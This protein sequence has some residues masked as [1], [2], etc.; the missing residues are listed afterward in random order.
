MK[1]IKL[2]LIIVGYIISLLCIKNY[3]F[4]ILGVIFFIYLFIKK[5]PYKYYLYGILILFIR[6]IIIY[7]NYEYKNVDNYLVILNKENYVILINNKLQQFVS[8]DLLEL[9]MFSVLQIEGNYKQLIQNSNFDLFS[10]KDY[11]SYRN[12]EY[13]LEVIGYRVLSDVDTFKPKLIEFLLNGLDKQSSSVINMLIFGNK[14]DKE[15]YNKLINL[16]VV[17]L[18]VVSGF[19]FNALEQVLVR[20]KVKWINI[21]I[22]ILFAFYLYILDFQIAA[23]RAFL[24]ICMKLLSKYLKILNNFMSYLLVLSLFLIINPFYI[25]HQ[26]FI[27]S[28]FLTF[29]LIF[30]KEIKIK[31][32]YK[33][34]IV[35]L[36]ALPII[37]S[38]NNEI[39]VFSFL[40]QLVLTP[41]ITLLFFSSLITLIF[42]FLSPLYLVLVNIFILIVN[43]FDFIPSM[44]IIKSFNF[45]ELLLYFLLIL[46]IIYLLA[47]KYNKKVGI[48]A[49]FLS[50]LFAFKYNYCFIF[51]QESVVFFDVGQ[52]D[53]TL[54]NLGNNKGHILIDTGGNINY[55]YATKVIIP[56]LNANGIKKLDY[57]LITHDDYDHNGSLESL[58]KNYNVNKVL[59][60]SYLKELEYKRFK[61]EKLNYGSNY[62]EDNEKSGVFYFEIFNKSFLIMGDASK[63]VEEE[64]MNKYSLDIDYLRIGH[65][66]SNTSSGLDFLKNID[67]NN[68]I[69]SVGKYNNY[70]H[71]HNEVIDNLN[72]LNYNVYRTDLHGMI[73]VTSNGIKTRFDV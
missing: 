44:I 24:M 2:S 36:C 65:H 20:I 3:Y 15:L 28:F 35:Y 58:V 67:C 5:K 43:I 62:N 9:N 4:I 55:D 71:P 8:Y 41:I 57:V 42:K 33:S 38:M 46:I 40:F 54:I 60:W 13:E 10:F 19:H 61:I 22:F 27:L 29:I 16:G 51:E 66:G 30:I 48:Y 49:C 64:I 56:Y 21:L 68:A 12:I 73:I 26:G 53:C 39:N 69:I 37:I 18:F 11:L 17:Q 52:G 32:L 1:E 45:I 25:Y 63:R 31:K 23:F 47:I 72:K 50:L 14:E 70:G 59:D 6:L 7:N 34:F